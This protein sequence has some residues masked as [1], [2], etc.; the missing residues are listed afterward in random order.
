MRC[1]RFRRLRGLF[2]LF[3]PGGGGSQGPDGLPGGR[4]RLLHL[5][6]GT[7]YVHPWT[8][9]VLRLQLDL[10]WYDHQ[11]RQSLGMS[12]T[13]LP[14]TLFSDFA[15]YFGR[16]IVE[17]HRGPLVDRVAQLARPVEPPALPPQYPR[18][19]GRDLECLP[20]ER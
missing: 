7:E 10:R 8:E 11:S 3:Q 15:A 6:M 14:A 16:L 12:V 2:R 17:D 18:H 19:S 9:R 20:G 13:D 1:V 4:I 5:P